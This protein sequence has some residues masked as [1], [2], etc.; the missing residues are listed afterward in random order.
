[1]QLVDDTKTNRGAALLQDALLK[2]D[3]TVTDLL[4]LFADEEIEIEKV[5]PGLYTAA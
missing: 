4:E 2:T 1:M 3:G 5:I